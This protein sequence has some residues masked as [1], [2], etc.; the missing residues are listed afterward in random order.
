MKTYLAQKLRP[1]FLGLTM[2]AMPNQFM[3]ILSFLFSTIF[4][5]FGHTFAE[6]INPEAYLSIVETLQ[7]QAKKTPPSFPLE[8]YEGGTQPIIK[9]LRYAYFG[10]GERR[11]TN[12]LDFHPA[13]DLAYFPTEKG[14]VTAEDGKSIKVRAPQTYLKKVYA[15]H[16]GELES[17]ALQG[18]GYKVKLKHTLEKPYFDNKGRAYNHYYTCYRHLD[19]R[20]L[21]YLDEVAKETTGNPKA[22]HKNLFGKYVFEAGE[23]IALAGFNPT[24]TKGRQRVHLDFSL[25]MYKD[26]DKGENLRKYALNPLL[27]FPSFHYAD[28]HSYEIKEDGLPSYQITIDESTLVAPTK[29]A[30]GRVTVKIHS[31]GWSN[32]TYTPV[33][34]F[35]LNGLDVVLHNDGKYLKSHHV[36]RHL[37]LAYKVKTF[38]QLDRSD[39]STPHFYAPLGEQVDVFEMD[40]ILPKIWIEKAG[41][42]WTKSGSLAI[43]ISSIWAM[44]LEGHSHSF[45]IPLAKN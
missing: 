40:I 9:G 12:R 23:Q 26:P 37:K 33:R 42:D 36:D 39:K 24:I 29:D 19:S 10:Y 4:L 6:K 45:S 44:Y 15:I 20:S 14:R 25:N 16:R 32:D 38:P 22:S 28:P 30:D 8:A 3:K 41:Y 27:L 21:N 11:Y 18:S 17:I 43:E 35:A 31:G 2:C 34:Y 7:Y 5:F 13:I 1:T